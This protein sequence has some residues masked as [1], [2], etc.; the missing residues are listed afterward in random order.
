MFKFLTYF[1]TFLATFGFFLSILLLNE[2]RRTHYYHGG[3]RSSGSH[4]QQI[5]G[6][7]LNYL[8]IHLFFDIISRPPYFFF[9]LCTEISFSWVYLHILSSGIMWFLHEDLWASWTARTFFLLFLLTFG[10]TFPS[11]AMLS[12][13]FIER[14]E[15]VFERLE[16]LNHLIFSWYFFFYLWCGDCRCRIV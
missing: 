5:V 12:S 6:N 1:L 11:P 3:S 16:S 9:A 8:L 14:D 10:K 15:Y 4:I 7:S 13:T 2:S